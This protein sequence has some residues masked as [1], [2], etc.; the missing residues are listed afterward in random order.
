MRAD[1]GRRGVL[2]QTWT[3]LGPKTEKAVVTRLDAII[4]L[5]PNAPK[6]SSGSLPQRLLKFSLWTVV[7]D[8]AFSYVNPNK[9]NVRPRY[10]RGVRLTCFAAFLKMAA[11]KAKN[12]STM[13]L[14]PRAYPK[15]AGKLFF[16]EIHAAANC[17]AKKG[18]KT[19]AKQVERPVMKRIRGLAPSELPSTADGERP[20]CFVSRSRASGDQ[21]QGRSSDAPAQHKAAAVGKEGH[22]ATRLPL[23]RR[24]RDCWR[25]RSC[26]ACARFR[27]VA[28][29]AATL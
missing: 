9:A 2:V 20:C 4:S 21:E 17:A 1:I 25:S 19:S 11:K 15:T 27:C 18:A 8:I 3:V 16:G 10:G 26:G 5:C 22:A 13:P 29:A 24:A 23:R 6:T 12:A 7:L 28:A 14:P